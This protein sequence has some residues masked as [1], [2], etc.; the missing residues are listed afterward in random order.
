[1]VGGTTNGGST[2]LASMR[3]LSRILRRE[4]DTLG[5]FLERVGSGH[6]DLDECIDILRSL[7]GVELHRAITAREAARE[8][9]LGA[10]ATLRLLADTAPSPWTAVLGAH[11]GALLALAAAVADVRRD[12]LIDLRESPRAAAFEI[13]RSLAEFLA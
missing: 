3:E 11:R 2:D 6:T 9:G 7:G 12:E 1:M 10:D 8:L 4:R 5:L 13:P